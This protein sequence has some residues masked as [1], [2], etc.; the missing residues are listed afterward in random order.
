MNW[1]ELVG[2]GLNWFELVGTVGG[3]RAEHGTFKL[4]LLC[5]SYD[6][7]SEKEVVLSHVEFSRCLEDFDA[8]LEAEEQLVDLKQATAGVPAQVKRFSRSQT[9]QVLNNHP[10]DLDFQPLRDRNHL[11]G[12]DLTCTR[13]RCGRC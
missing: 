1:F 13:R 2:T 7:S 9:S 11:R 8:H 3:T 10:Q 12:L 4:K 5:F 6:S